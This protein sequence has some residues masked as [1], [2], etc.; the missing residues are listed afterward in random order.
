MAAGLEPKAID[1]VQLHDRLGSLKEVIESHW[2]VNDKPDLFCFGLLEVFDVKQLAALVAPRSRT[3]I[4]ASERAAA[5]LGDLVPSFR[6]L[7]GEVE[8]NSSTEGGN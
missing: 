4:D 1:A 3:V 8:F 6:T 5:E 2:G 7:G